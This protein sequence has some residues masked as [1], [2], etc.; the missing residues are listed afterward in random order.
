MKAQYIGDINDYR[1]Y[2][3]LRG[4]YRES[5]ASIGVHW[6]LTPDDGSNDGRKRA[7]LG[8]AERWR[9]HDSELFDALC[10]VIG[11]NRSPSLSEIERAPPMA[12]FHYFSELVPDNANL[13]R[14]VMRRANEQ[15]AQADLVFFDPDNGFEIASTAKGRQGSAKY[16]YY[17]ELAAIYRAGKSAL[18]Y[19]HYPRIE[20]RLFEDGLAQRIGESCPDAQVDFISTAHVAFVLI[21][22]GE[23]DYIRAA[24]DRAARSAHSDLY[25]LR[26][27]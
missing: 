12:A 1:K 27:R 20:R 16:L 6:M 14:E 9:S 7:Y 5:G 10:A 13:R 24:A 11:P 18:V 3:L 19:Q 21:T 23:H 17:D 25:K 22:Q 2:A 26:P 15:L 8:Q 4:L